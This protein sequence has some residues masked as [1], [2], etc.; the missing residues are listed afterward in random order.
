ME[1]GTRDQPLHARF[2]AYDEFVQI[3]DEILSLDLSKEPTE[4][5]DLAEHRQLQKLIVMV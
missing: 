5:Q 3:Q 2:E 4:E 1:D